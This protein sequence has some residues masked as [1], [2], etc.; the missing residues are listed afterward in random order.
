MATPPEVPAQE[1]FETNVS[2]SDVQ[3]VE[4]SFRRHPASKSKKAAK[5]ADVNFALGVL[6]SG[7]M[8]IGVRLSAEFDNPG[9]A[10]LK[11]TA[12]TELTLEAEDLTE[13]E[14]DQQ[15]AAIASQLGPVVLYPYIR[16]YVADLTRRSGIKP[17]TLPILQIGR[18]FNLPVEA[19]QRKAAP[20]ET[21]PDTAT[22]KPKR[23]RK[24][25][26]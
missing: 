21:S 2:P 19:V 5:P 1:T 26:R 17:V 11:V 14:A 24:P 6:R 25:N 20:K 12:L 22:D 8:S 10:A 9:E 18:M 3:I 7:P 16:E 15:L 23:P 4:V 13:S